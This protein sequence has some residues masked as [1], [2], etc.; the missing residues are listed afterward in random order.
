MQ[1]GWFQSWSRYQWHEMRAVSPIFSE[2]ARWLAQRL[3]PNPEAMRVR[4]GD[5][6]P[7]W[8]F[9]IKRIGVGLKRL[10]P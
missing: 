1:R 9:M 3:W 5:D 4:Y 10:L 2:R 6:D 8:K 7:V